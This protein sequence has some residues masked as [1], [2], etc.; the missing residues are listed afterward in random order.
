MVAQA[1]V[2][3][4]AE[5]RHAPLEPLEGLPLTADPLELG[6]DPVERVGAREVA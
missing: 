2:L 1:R 5:L 6:R 4:E 3:V